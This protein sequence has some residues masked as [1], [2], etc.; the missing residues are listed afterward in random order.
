MDSGHH[1]ALIAVVGVGA[2]LGIVLARGRQVVGSAAVA[3]GSVVQA[4]RRIVV[5]E[6][7]EGNCALG[8]RREEG[9]GSLRLGAERSIAAV[10]GIGLRGVS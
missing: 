9:V 1:I 4:G 5:A 3:E 8:A 2:V 6:E 10:V 7:A